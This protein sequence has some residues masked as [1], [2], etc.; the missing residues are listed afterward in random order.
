MM[1]ILDD[2]SGLEGAVG[3]SFCMGILHV[4]ARAVLAVLALLFCDRSEVEVAAVPAIL[5]DDLL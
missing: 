5:M 2:S 3:I 1:A 4:L